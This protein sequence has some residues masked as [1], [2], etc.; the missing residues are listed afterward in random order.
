MATN[1]GAGGRCTDRPKI[2]KRKSVVPVT[3]PRATAV[4]PERVQHG[5]VGAS[6]TAFCG[7]R[8]NVERKN[9]VRFGRGDGEQK[10]F[11]TIIERQ[12]KKNNGLV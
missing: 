9:R 7:R 5:S 8:A 3:V 10:N 4:N 1:R 6:S 2:P 12:K 11:K